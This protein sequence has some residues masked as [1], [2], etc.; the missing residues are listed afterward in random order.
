[1]FKIKNLEDRPEDY[2][3]FATYKGTIKT[4][5]E[6]IVFDTDFTFVKNKPVSVSGNL[7][8][9]LAQSRFGKHF[10]VTKPGEHRGLFQ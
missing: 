1:M 8:N 7:A 10:N 9:S 3:Q 6:E 5:P 4:D 2:G